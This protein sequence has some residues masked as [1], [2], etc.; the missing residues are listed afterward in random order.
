[1]VTLI[2]E[3]RNAI[4]DKKTCLQTY[5]ETTDG[6]YSFLHINLMQP[7]KSKMFMRKF[8]ECLKPNKNYFP[9]IN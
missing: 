8:V 1:M 6:P 3:E 5:H 9:Y 4:Y 7:D 2:I